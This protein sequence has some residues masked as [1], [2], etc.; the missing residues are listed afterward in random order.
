MFDRWI[1]DCLLEFLS[2][3][4]SMLCECKYNNSIYTDDT[5][6]INT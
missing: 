4:S 1:S 5:V 3:D 2:G 6:L